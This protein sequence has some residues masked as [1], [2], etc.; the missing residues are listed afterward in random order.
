MA[1]C[2]LA[3]LFAYGLPRGAL[4]NAG[5]LVGS[6]DVATNTIELDVHGLASGSPFSLRAEAGGLLPSPLVSG[7][8]YYAVPVSEAR[9]SV[10]ATAGG[11]AIDL[12]TTG[13]RVVMVA[14][15]PEAAVREWASRLVDDMLSGHVVPLV[16]PYPEIVRM[17]T[18]ELS[19]GRLLALAGLQSKSLAEITD[20]A[21]LRLARWSRGALVRGANAPQSAALAV[22]ATSAYRDPRGWRDFGGL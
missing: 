11:G 21:H 9:F 8:L 3:D 16:A 20:A 17:T 6:V 18:A 15:L 13:S 5:R 2:D 4:R 12:T 22:S 10:A 1:Y 7:T 14:D 19:A